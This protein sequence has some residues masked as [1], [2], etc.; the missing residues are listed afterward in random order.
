MLEIEKEM[1]KTFRNRKISGKYRF[2]LFSGFLD[3]FSA[4]WTS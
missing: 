1:V 4:F 3:E 2:P